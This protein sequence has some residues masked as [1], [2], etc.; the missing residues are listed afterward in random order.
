MK[1]VEIEDKA[2]WDFFVKSHALDNG[3]LQSWSW[4]EFQK[5]VGKKIW[6]LGVMDISGHIGVDE[7]L[8]CA[9]VVKYPLPLGASY[10]YTPRGP[11]LRAKKAGP[12][13]VLNILDVL[14]H[15][16]KIKG[17]KEGALFWRIDPPVFNTEGVQSL[18]K[19][20]HFRKSQHEMQPKNTLIIDLRKSEEELLAA[21]HQKT[22]YNIGLAKKKGVNVRLSGAETKEGGQDFEKFWDLLQ[23]TA[24]RD[25]FRTHQ[26][27]Y[28]EKLFQTKTGVIFIAERQGVF[29]AAAM[30]CFF[31]NWAL[32]LHG[33]SC[34][35][36]REVMAPYLLHWF[37]I[38]EA[39]RLGCLF[40]DFW[41]V[42]EG[43]W[44]GFSRFKQGFSPETP[45]TP[46]VGTWE[47][48]LTYWRYSLYSSALRL[49]RR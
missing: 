21:M 12:L 48:P 38:K 30:V 39:K 44:A 7:L 36:Q 16:I 4:G 45:P 47:Y 5:S 20:L 2:Q 10:F 18:M 29:L 11:I 41:G 24:K 22:R 13:L 3:F 34:S 26:K 40:Y 17:E 14:F 23:E 25:K 1:V 15:E 31:N 49:W 8:A 32:Y 28:Y 42:G 19:T 46:Y 27:K 35:H 6:R 33:A 43:S 9:L 37:A